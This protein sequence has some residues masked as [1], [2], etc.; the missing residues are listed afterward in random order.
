[1]SAKDGYG[2]NVLPQLLERDDKYVATMVP[3]KYQGLTRPSE[4]I[5]DPG[6]GID[7]R[8]SLFLFLQGWIFPTD[9]SINFALSQTGNMSSAPPAL[10]VK[11]IKG[12]WVTVIQNIGFPSGKNK[13]IVVDLTGKYLTKDHRVRIVTNMQIYWD[14][15]F[16]AGNAHEPITVTRMNPASADLHY[17]GF[18]AMYRKGGRYGPHWFDYYS[19]STDPKY[20]DLTGYYTRYG[21]VRPLLLNS[22]EEYIISNA[23][24]EVSLQFDNRELPDLKNGGKRDYL[25]YSVGWVKDGDL[26][27]A[28]GNTVGPLPFHAMSRY[29]YGPGEHY[30]ADDEH[31]QYLKKYNTR[32]IS[33]QAF[34]NA[35][36]D[37]KG[38]SGN[39]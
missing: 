25:M 11:N 4:L 15:A 13:T 37:R 18:S 5:L 2:N 16:F 6:K 7:T 30:P 36:V 39:R 9:A 29:P 14:C 21:D 38:N 27:T 24:D 19:V 32:Y 17:R 23:G 22:D 33:D 1:M 3:G 35:L 20:R 10:Q 8:D 12:D 31:A 34:R 28:T 26:N